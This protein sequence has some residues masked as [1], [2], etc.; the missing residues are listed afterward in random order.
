MKRGKRFGRW[1]CIFGFF[2]EILSLLESSCSEILFVVV[3]VVAHCR[4][5]LPLLRVIHLGGNELGPFPLLEEG[6]RNL[7]HAGVGREVGISLDVP[8][9]RGRDRAIVIGRV[10]N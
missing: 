1:R 6:G 10:S 3:V 9:E 7:N 2:C 4:D 5:P 8:E